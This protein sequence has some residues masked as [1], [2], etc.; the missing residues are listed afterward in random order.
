MF[1]IRGVSE[2]DGVVKPT[3][4]YHQWPLLGEVQFA[5]QITDSQKVA[6]EI[7]PVDKKGNAA[8]VDGAP[9]WSTDNDQVVALT[10]SSDGL[11]CVVS[12]VGPLGVAAVSVKADADLGAG[13]KPVFG[14]ISFEV[15]SGEAAT[16]TI[17]AGTPEEQDAT[18]APPAPP[19]PPS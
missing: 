5:M 11:S 19:V 4:Q 6:L 10:P 3:P 17:N 14:T 1:V 8:K 18:P 13:V 2:Y 9:V 16:M 15:T 7:K 12:A